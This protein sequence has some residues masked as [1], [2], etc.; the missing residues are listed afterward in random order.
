MEETPESGWWLGIYASLAEHLLSLVSYYNWVFAPGRRKWFYSHTFRFPWPLQSLIIGHLLVYCVTNT[1]VCVCVWL[2]TIASA[3]QPGWPVQ[4]SHETWEA[5]ASDSVYP[6]VPTASI[7]PVL[8]WWSIRFD[9]ALE[10]SSLL[11]PIPPDI[12][13]RKYSQQTWMCSSGVTHHIYG[14][15]LKGWTRRSDRVEKS[16]SYLEVW[17]SLPARIS[18]S[19]DVNIELKPKPEVLLMCRQV[20]INVL[21]DRSP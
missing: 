17:L 10:A 20:R 8:S 19:W 12:D 16:D 15:C 11:F 14:E 5:A 18:A 9:L 6:N 1:S 7:L 3:A 2:H 21:T 13:W 4:N